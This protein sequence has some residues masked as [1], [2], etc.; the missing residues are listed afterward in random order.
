MDLWMKI[1]DEKLLISPGKAFCCYEP[2]WFRLVFSDSV[3]KII[4]CI[5][6]LQQLLCDK[7][8]EPV[9]LCSCPE[10]NKCTELDDNVSANVINTP[11][12]DVSEGYSQLKKIAVF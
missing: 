11:V 6:R 1:L 3:D 4:L 12:D 7:M 10:R 8:G 9:T 2:G 5:Q